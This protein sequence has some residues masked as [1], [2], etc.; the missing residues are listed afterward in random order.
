MQFKLSIHAKDVMTTRNIL[1][2]W[3]SSTTEDPSVKVIVNEQ[4][5]H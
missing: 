3:V 4:E 2:E 1:E 5:V